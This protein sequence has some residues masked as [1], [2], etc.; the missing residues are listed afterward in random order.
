MEL[1]GLRPC[2]ADGTVNLD[3]FVAGG[4]LLDIV[5]RQRLAACF[6][7]VEFHVLSRSRLSRLR[8]GLIFARYLMVGQ[9]SG[10]FDPVQSGRRELKQGRAFGAIDPAVITVHCRAIVERIGG[11]LEAAVITV[12]DFQGLLPSNRRRIRHK[13]TCS[14]VISSGRNAARNVPIRLRARVRVLTF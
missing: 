3:L 5:F 11:A 1:N 12:D 7:D 2:G 10:R 13:P 8:D 4:A 6:T 14:E 9:S